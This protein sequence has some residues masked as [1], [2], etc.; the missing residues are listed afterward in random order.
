[1]MIVCVDLV[2]RSNEEDQCW[3]SEVSVNWKKSTNERGYRRTEKKLSIR[4]QETKKFWKKR[5]WDLLIFIYN[6]YHF[7]RQ[8]VLSNQALDL[9]KKRSL[10]RKW[11]SLAKNQKIKNDRKL[12]KKKESLIFCYNHYPQLIYIDEERERERKRKKEE[13]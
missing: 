6:D 2:F 4:I 11:N 9:G 5:W 8:T 7:K 10:D 13:I 12:K 1:M 3:R